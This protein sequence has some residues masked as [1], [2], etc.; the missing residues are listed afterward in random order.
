VEIL[1]VGEA[2]LP[3]SGSRLR[4]SIVRRNR[5]GSADPRQRNRRHRRNGGDGSRD[6]GFDLQAKVFASVRTA[7]RGN[8]SI[9][10]SIVPTG[11]C[12]TLI[13]PAPGTAWTACRIAASARFVDRP[14]GKL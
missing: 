13:Q 11:W 6:N 5:R 14:G 4:K 10:P 1:S 8:T 7:A 9:E 2:E 3:H 12:S